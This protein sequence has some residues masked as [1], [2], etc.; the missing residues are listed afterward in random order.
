MGSKRPSCP[1]R[2]TNEKTFIEV[3][4]I[5][6]TSKAYCLLCIFEPGNHVTRKVRLERLTA[7]LRKNTPNKRKACPPSPRGKTELRKKSKTQS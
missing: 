3:Y 4:Y 5:Y 1:D 2:S 7:A 6:R